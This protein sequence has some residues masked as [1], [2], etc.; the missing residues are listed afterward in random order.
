MKKLS[1]MAVIILVLGGCTSTPEKDKDPPPKAQD[2]PVK[3]P[4]PP[5]K[6]PIK[7]EQPPPTKP[8]TATPDPDLVGRA[9]AKG[10]ERGRIA[11]VVELIVKSKSFDR[12]F[13]AALLFIPDMREG[14]TTALIEQTSSRDGRMSERSL[15]A[16]GAMA[17]LRLIPEPQRKSAIDTVTKLVRTERAPS[18][19][20]AAVY[21]LGSLSGHDAGQDVTDALGR[22]VDED[23]AQVI[24]ACAEVLGDLQFHGAASA[25]VTALNRAHDR[26]AAR[27]LVRALGRLGGKEASKR[28]VDALNAPDV[29]D[30]EA[31]ASALGE[32]GGGEAA[33][34][35]RAA[36]ERQEE[37]PSVRRAAIAALERMGGEEAVKALK[38]CLANLSGRRE[39]AWIVTT[40]DI[41]ETLD[42]LQRK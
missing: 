13:E 40:R 10:W 38:T 39:E 26:Y 42:R 28:L 24:R 19:W 15:E 34:A 2:P 20:A 35:L 1:H 17:H 31:A 32:A 36:I 29:A 9:T 22:A 4:P 37:S 18:S 11:L 30:R 12:G 5:E 6:S 23:S 25:L 14:I 16:L 33:N 41:A 21:A 8:T 7:V 3:T 27:T